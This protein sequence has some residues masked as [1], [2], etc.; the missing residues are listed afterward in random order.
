MATEGLVNRTRYLRWQGLALA[1]F[2]VA[3]GLLSALAVTGLG[4]GLSMVQ[5]REFMSALR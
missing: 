3:I 2:S 4:A 1:Q 5:N